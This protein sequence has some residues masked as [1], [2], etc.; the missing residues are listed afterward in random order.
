MRP[1]PAWESTQKENNMHFELFVDS[2][3]NLPDSL[4]LERNIHVIP[5]LF[6]V[7]GEERSCLSGEPFRDTAIKFYA[8][9]RSGADVKTSLISKQ[10]VIDAL[11]P[12]LEAGKDV[13]LITITA[14]L[15]GTFE[16]ATQAKKELSS[17][18]PERKI[19]VM[20]GAN[21]SLGE[22]L[23]ALRVADLRDMGESI[24]ACEEW[25]RENAYRMNSFVTVGDLKYLRRSGRVSLVAALAGTILGIKAMLKANGESPAR[26]VFS[27]RERGRKKA[28]SALLSAYE[29]YVDKAMPQTI[30][31]AHADCEEEA[32]ALAEEL[33]KR[34]AGEIIIEHYDLCTGSHV[35]PDTMALFFFGRDRRMEPA[36]APSHFKAKKPHPVK[37]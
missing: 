7:N 37:T 26:L 34:G 31:I 30:A 12:V 20:D 33:K 36:A 16:Q 32:T 6:T 29:T 22:G 2:A 8:E 11:T 10:R 19:V 35:G 14:S 9:M 17:L 23:L 27:G 5:Y 28:L 1:P 25:L 13:F 3:A 24:E 4:R 21:A 18:F 15:S